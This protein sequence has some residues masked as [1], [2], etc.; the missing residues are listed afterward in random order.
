MEIQGTDSINNY[1]NRLFTRSPRAYLVNTFR[2]CR[3]QERVSLIGDFPLPA[4]ITKEAK[5]YKRVYKW[6]QIIKAV[7]ESKELSALRKVEKNTLVSYLQS[8]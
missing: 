6:P 1:L 2:K 5:W 4:H 3:N 8:L 7:N